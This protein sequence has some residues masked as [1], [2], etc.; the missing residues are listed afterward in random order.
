MAGQRKQKQGFN[1]VAAFSAGQK[2]GDEDIS[3]GVTNSLDATKDHSSTSSQDN[4]GDRLGL[5]IVH[6]ASSHE[7]LRQFYEK[8]KIK[9]TK[10]YEPHQDQSITEPS[11]EKFRTVC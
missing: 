3:G 4:L 2:D 6:G 11:I 5:P 10:L 7:T 8:N 1:S 9:T